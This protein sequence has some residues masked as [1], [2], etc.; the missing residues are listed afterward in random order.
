MRA[1]LNL[2]AFALILLGPSVAIAKVQPFIAGWDNFNEPLNYSDS[3]VK[4][5]YSPKSG[6]VS[7]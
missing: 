4:W 1:S 2:A 3:N 5:S 6:S 7:I